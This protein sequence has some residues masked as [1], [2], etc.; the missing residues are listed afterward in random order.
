MQRGSARNYRDAEAGVM[1][2]KRVDA[3]IADARK[4]GGK[5]NWPI[6][7]IAFSCFVPGAGHHFYDDVHLEVGVE[8]QLNSRRSLESNHRILYLRNP[9]PSSALY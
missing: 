4:F 5:G 7:E 9:Y 2:S 8:E 1:V 6:R 3:S